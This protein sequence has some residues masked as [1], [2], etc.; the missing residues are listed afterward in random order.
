M[1]RDAAVQMLKINNRQVGRPARALP[2]W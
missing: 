2:K 1:V